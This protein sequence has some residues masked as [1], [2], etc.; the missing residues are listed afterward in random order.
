MITN[1]VVC[2][3]SYVK[4]SMT[5]FQNTM[6]KTTTKT[7]VFFIIIQIF[8]LNLIFWLHKICTIYRFSRYY[9]WKS[10]KKNMKIVA[11]HLN[12]L[13]IKM[14]HLVSMMK[15]ND[16]WQSKKCFATSNLFANLVNNNCYQKIFCMI[17]LNNYCRG[18]RIK[19]LLIKCKISNVYVR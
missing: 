14:D 9:C 1:I 3:Q 19:A 6:N 7:Y 15:R 2:T 10:V 5:M 17:A 12:N 18:Q 16:H 13:K 11:M 8:I 4:L